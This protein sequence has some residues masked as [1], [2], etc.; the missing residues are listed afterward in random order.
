MIYSVQQL[1]ERHNFTPFCILDFGKIIKYCANDYLQIRV[2]GLVKHFLDYFYLLFGL[3]VRR[4]I[5]TLYLKEII[6]LSYLVHHCKIL[7]LLKFL[8]WLIPLLIGF[9]HYIRILIIEFELIHKVI[10]LL[11]ILLNFIRLM[12]IHQILLKDLL[13]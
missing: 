1:R 8:G 7:Y 2:I 12:I 13:C 6:F 11:I 9:L 10:N 5:L 4:E 3:F